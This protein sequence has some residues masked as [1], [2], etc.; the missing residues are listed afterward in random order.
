V[1]LFDLMNVIARAQLSLTQA[2]VTINDI[3]ARGEVSIHKADSLVYDTDTAW[4]EWDGV[5]DWRTWAAPAAERLGACAKWVEV[6]ANPA[7]VEAHNG[8]LAY[9]WQAACESLTLPT[10]LNMTGAPE[11]LHGDLQPKWVAGLAHAIRRAEH[12]VVLVVPSHTCVWAIARLLP[13]HSG[14]S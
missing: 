2:R 9:V 12:G 1:V 11:A 6:T 8:P 14:P 4:C 13:S 5:A 7:Q 3:V 10:V